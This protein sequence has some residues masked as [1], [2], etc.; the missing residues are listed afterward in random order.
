MGG[1][2]MVDQAQA[3]QALEVANRVRTD[4]AQALREIKAGALTVGEALD[5][6]RAQGIQVGR[7]LTAQRAWGP[8]KANKLLNRH[9]IWPTRRV[10]DLTK[11]QRRVLREATER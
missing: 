6:P 3:F 4:G 11:R 10:R 7:L 2:L 9:G 1:V 8:T 5:D